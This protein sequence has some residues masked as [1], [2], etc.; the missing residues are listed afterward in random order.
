MIYLLYLKN[1]IKS[2]RIDDNEIKIGMMYSIH[3]F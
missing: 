1:K 3:N 2:I